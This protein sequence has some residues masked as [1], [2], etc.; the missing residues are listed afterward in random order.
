MKTDISLDDSPVASDPP[1][2][3]TPKGTVAVDPLP[4]VQNVLVLRSP[5]SA[6]EASVIPSTDD[7]KLQEPGAL[8]VGEADLNKS[9]SLYAR[10][11]EIDSAVSSSCDL[12]FV[13]V[14]QAC[15]G[16]DA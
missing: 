7:A 9:D 3:A 11:I 4:R 2:Q 10:L 8:E 5:C 15:P 1:L 13:P 14:V 16:R 6:I 12:G